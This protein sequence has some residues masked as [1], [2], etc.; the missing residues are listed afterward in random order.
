MDEVLQP[1][2]LPIQHL[3]AVYI[4]GIIVLLHDIV[5]LLVMHDMH[6]MV[7]AVHKHLVV[8]VSQ[9][10]PHQTQAHK[11]YD[12]HD[13]IAPHHEIVHILVLA[14]IIGTD[15]VAVNLQLEHKVVYDYLQMLHGTPQLAYHKH[16]TVQI[17][18]LPTLDH[19]I[20][21]QAQLNVYSNVTHDIHG[22]QI[23]VHLLLHEH[24]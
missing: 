12:H 9:Q 18:H 8:E 1:T 17:G 2:P 20:P 21:L 6:G 10:M 13:H 23:H 22:H 4:L 3:V 11:T 5:R 15:L 24:L 7:L 16:G 19:T 14:I